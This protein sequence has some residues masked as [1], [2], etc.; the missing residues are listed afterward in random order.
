MKKVLL[1]FVFLLILNKCQADHNCTTKTNYHGFGCLLMNL[2]SENGTLEI[3]HLT[4]NETNIEDNKTRSKADV[5]WISIHESHL[6]TLPIHIFDEFKNMKKI[7]I[8]YTTGLTVLDTPYFDHKMTLILIGKTDLEIIGE[9]AFRGLYYL[10]ILVLDENKIT[11]VH[12]NAFKD[13][14]RLERLEMEDNRIESLDDKIFDKNRNL[15]A[16]RLSRNQLIVINAKLFL[17]NPKIEEIDFHK[18]IIWQIEKDFLRNSSIIKY[19]DFSS[20][21]C[22]SGYLVENEKW[23][24]FE[25][26]LQDCY[27]NYAMMN[28]NFKEILTVNASKTE[29]ISESLKQNHDRSQQKERLCVDKHELQLTDSMKNEIKQIHDDI[30]SKFFIIYCF[31][32]VMICI[33]LCV[34]IFIIHR[35]KLSTKG[36]CVGSSIELLKTG[37]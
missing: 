28:D 9:K 5:E 22:V 12:K 1:T 25:L 19:A 17:H 34:S 27:T 6:K 31:L 37:D 29:N 11:T 36:Y 7:S 23:S 2:N 13:L 35:L 15:R 18:N 16:V 33:F 21:D 10:E 8:T 20:N 26:K 3:I 32:F 4:D 30:V 24:S 14:V